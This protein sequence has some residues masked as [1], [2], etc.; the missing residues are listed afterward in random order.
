[1]DKHEKRIGRRKRGG[2][3]GNLN[4][5]KHGRYTAEA[6]A[7]RRYVR[8]L[9]REARATISLVTDSDRREAP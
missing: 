9:L 3:P 4:A 5:L 8:D 6:K 2:Q 1:M 7:Q